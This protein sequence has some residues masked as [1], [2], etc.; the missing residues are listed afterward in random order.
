MNPQAWN[1]TMHPSRLRPGCFRAVDVGMGAWLFIT[2]Q[3]NA[4]L[5]LRRMK[6]RGRRV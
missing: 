2:R 6:V 5:Y 3:T 1:Y 4:G